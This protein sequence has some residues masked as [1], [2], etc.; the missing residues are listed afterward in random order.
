MKTIILVRDVNQNDGLFINY[1]HIKRLLKQVLSLP[2]SC[3]KLLEVV[4]LDWNTCFTSQQPVPLLILFGKR[5]D[6]DKLRDLQS[7]FYAKNSL[8]GQCSVMLVECTWDLTGVVE[9]K[10]DMGGDKKEGMGMGRGFEIIEFVKEGEVLCAERVLTST[11]LE[12]HQFVPYAALN[13]MIMEKLHDESLQKA[14]FSATKYAHSP[15][16]MSFEGVLNARDLGGYRVTFP[17]GFLFRSAAL[18]KIT[19]TGMNNLCKKVALIFDLR[20]V[21]EVEKNGVFPSTVSL[22]PHTIRHFVPIF[23]KDS[24]APDIVAKRMKSYQHGSEGF[25]FVYRGILD[26]MGPTLHFIF[27]ETAAL[28]KSSHD[29]RGILIHCTAGKDRTGI[30]CALFLLLGGVDEE[31]V[32]MEYALTEA[33]LASFYQEMV[34]GNPRLTSERKVVARRMLGAPVDAMRR[35]LLVIREEYGG[36]RNL[37]EKSVE[38]DDLCVI[39]SHLKSSVIMPKL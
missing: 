20:S 11:K 19:Q 7:A 34:F 5:V 15:R 32:A 14:F 17:L 21:P 23:P 30:I 33:G 2:D 9:R 13:T 36:W 39:E 3:L 4:E 27:K 6:G 18:T 38:A 28:I 29:G 10:Q 12:N 16:W 24:Y 8:F 22:S 25:V 26:F 35:T 1:L 37:L 31:T